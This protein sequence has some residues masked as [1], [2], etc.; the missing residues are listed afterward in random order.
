MKQKRAARPMNGAYFIPTE[1]WRRGKAPT[2]RSFH[3]RKANRSSAVAV[4]YE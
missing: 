1:G 2:Q 4:G 3:L